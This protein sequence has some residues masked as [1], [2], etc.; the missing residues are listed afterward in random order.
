MW[1]AAC[2]P[3]RV[4]G[5]VASPTKKARTTGCRPALQPD[6]QPFP[7]SGWLGGN[8]NRLLAFV[9][10]ELARET[11]STVYYYVVATIENRDGQFVQ[12]GCAPNFQGNVLTLCTCK[13]LM[14]TVRDVANW[15]GVWVA[16]FSGVGA[17]G[18]RNALVYLARIQHAFESHCEL[19]HSGVLTESAKEA[20][21]ATTQ[22]MG[23]LYQP[24]VR[25]GNPF[26][27]KSYRQ[28]RPDHAHMPDAWRYDV[29][30]EGAG[31]RR[32][33][34][35]VFDPK[36]SFLWDQ[37]AYFTPNR[38]GIGQRKGELGALLERLEA[39]V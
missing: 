32:A 12:C 36:R 17:G 21:A 5:C 23:D 30:Y 6:H 22:R 20:K 39:I 33:A 38:L 7:R 31:G 25:P 34:L 35:L 11:G 10:R 2:S 16:G 29:D 14:R 26:T 15:P 18:G 1:R 13:H 4:A 3:P 9:R 8:L 28:P 27:I 37:P 24:K 19:W